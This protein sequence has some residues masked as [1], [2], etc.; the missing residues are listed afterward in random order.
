MTPVTPRPLKLCSVTV[1]QPGM[2]AGV[3]CSNAGKYIVNGKWVCGTHSPE[4]E[5]KRREKSKQR[6][7][8]HSSKMQLRLE[9]HEANRL[10][11]EHFDEM[12]AALES[13]PDFGGE[14]RTP[15]G[16]EYREWQAKV[17]AVL[18]KLEGV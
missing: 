6:Y 18:A 13:A 9:R 7:K 14:P 5:Q 16:H 1:S 8:E 2:F 4:A 12:K 15:F 10:K 3:R 17:R 11:L